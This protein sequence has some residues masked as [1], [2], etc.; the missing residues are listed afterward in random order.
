[1]ADRSTGLDPKLEAFVRLAIDVSA[2]HLYSPGV[3]RHIRRALELG[4]SREEILEVI[5]LMS[6]VGIHAPAT[7]LPILEEE[8]AATGASDDTGAARKP[9]R[10]TPVCDSFRGSGQFNPEWE[11]LYRWSPDWL[12]R[13][14]AVALPFW[15]DDV[16]PPLWVELLCVAG[17]AAVTHMY[18]SGTRRHIRTALELGA[19]R[20]Q[21][22]QVL[23]VVA[24]Q[25]FQ[26]HDV[27]VP[28]L[29]EECARVEE[30]ARTDG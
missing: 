16:L 2:T 21:I 11:L 29:D 24:E 12:E 6:V 8:L 25:G 15:Q 4:A 22:L 18:D 1:V 9:Q 28:I 14:L 10:P 3:R 7:G 23:Q 20:D 17:D 5:T 19:T 26:S 30:A 13:F 27:G